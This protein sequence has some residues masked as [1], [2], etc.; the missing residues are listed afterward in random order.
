MII[1]LRINEDNK[2]IISEDELSTDLSHSDRLVLREDRLHDSVYTQRCI[3]TALNSEELQSQ[4]I[5]STAPK[6]SDIQI[7]QLYN[8]RLFFGL[9][10]LLVEFANWN[11]RPFIGNS[12]F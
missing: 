12:S 10:C 6:R 7:M 4:G 8:L 9:L 3:N 1:Y 11:G 5:K 2:Q